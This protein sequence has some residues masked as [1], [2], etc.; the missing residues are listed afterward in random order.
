[1]AKPEELRRVTQFAPPNA[2]ATANML[3]RALAALGRPM[4]SLRADHGIAPAKLGILGR[5]ERAGRPMTATELAA[6]ERLQPQSLT[7]IIADLEEH[8]LI[9]RTPR[10]SDRRQLDIAITPE[11]SRLIRRDAHRQ[12]L[13]LA[14][15][16][17]KSLSPAERTILALAAELLDRIADHP[18]EG[19][20][21]TKAIRTPVPSAETESR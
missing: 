7:R 3:R 16:M 12:A 18:I 6:H 20:G 14:D 1:M 17:E 13:W 19:I 9:A 21:D 11:G 8:G 4:R 15:A 2:L 10:E 5:L